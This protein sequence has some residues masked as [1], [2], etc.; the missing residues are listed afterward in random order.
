MR[1]QRL[2]PRSPR[3]Q[4]EDESIISTAPLVPSIGTG[5]ADRRPEFAPAFRLNGFDDW[6][7]L[8]SNIAADN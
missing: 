3:R 5:G 6:E 1:P 7:F 4:C 2:R 8:D